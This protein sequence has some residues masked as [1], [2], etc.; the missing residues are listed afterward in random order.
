LRYTDLKYGITLEFSL[1]A[2][3]AGLLE[4]AGDAVMDKSF[5]NI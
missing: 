3:I 1:R 2:L 4:D 5:E